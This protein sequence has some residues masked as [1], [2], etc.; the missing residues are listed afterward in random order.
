M[1]AL[2]R[3]SKVRALAEHEAASRLDQ[4][5]RGEAEETNVEAPD[6]KSGAI[7]FVGPARVGIVRIGAQLGGELS[8]RAPAGTPRL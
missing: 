2:G 8:D 3:P 4:H 5:R 7:V 1:L 6:H